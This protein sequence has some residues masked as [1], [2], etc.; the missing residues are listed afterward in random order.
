MA[1]V[2]NTNS[3]VTVAE[4]NTYFGNRLDVAAWDNASDTLKEQS[5]ITATSM[6]D[7]LRW[8]GLAA[9]ADQPLAFPR[10]GIYFDPRLGTNVT[11]DGAS[12]PD[13]ILKATYEQAY[14]LLNNDGLLDATNR[15][16]S[17][18]VGPIKLERITTANKRPGVV[19]KLTSPL[20]ER[21]G[22]GAWWRA[23]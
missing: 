1:L 4:A 14:H 9:S 8:V 3:Y 15:V 20:L 10:T 6:L 5:L 17:L 22:M 19:R 7:E 23:N 21:G 12:V 2:K 13:R 16:S 18:E 11:L